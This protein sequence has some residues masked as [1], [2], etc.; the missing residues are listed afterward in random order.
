MS[1]DVAQRLQEEK[2]K[3][4]KPKTK[5]TKYRS[6]DYIRSDEED[7]EDDLVVTKKPRTITFSDDEE[8][9]VKPTNAKSGREYALSILAEKRKQRQLAQQKKQEEEERNK[10][11]KTVDEMME[12]YN[13]D[14]QLALSDSELAQIEKETVQDEFDVIEMENIDDII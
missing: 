11:V 12:E 10:P 1:A 2:R 3:S 9:Q 7:S 13:D 6:N 8:D 14:V 4:V 5:K